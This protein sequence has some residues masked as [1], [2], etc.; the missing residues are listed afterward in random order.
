LRRERFGNKVPAAWPSLDEHIA[1]LNMPQT[2]SGFHLDD[3]RDTVVH[4]Q[5]WLNLSANAGLRGVT[6]AH[7]DK[8]EIERNADRITGWLVDNITQFEQH[9]V[10]E[11]SL[12]GAVNLSADQVAVAV[13]RLENHEVVVRDPVALTKPPRF[14][15]KP[16]RNWPPTRD[17]LVA[18]RT[19][20]PA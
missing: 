19:A 10:S 16:G 17:K 20:T 5:T 18:S 14:L 2:L 12:T 11:D 3:S 4:T 9:G 7:R 13:D 1:R 15:I 6:M 8:A